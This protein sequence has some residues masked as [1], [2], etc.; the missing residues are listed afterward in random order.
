MAIRFDLVVSRSADALTDATDGT[1]RL[2]PECRIKLASA[3]SRTSNLR[4]YDGFVFLL[5][6]RHYMR[7]LLLDP[8]TAAREQRR[9]R[10]VGT[11]APA[12]WLFVLGLGVLLPILLG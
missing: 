12:V 6:E 4:G 9:V 10:P 11:P 1:N 5:L 2:E 8:R 7:W 3:A